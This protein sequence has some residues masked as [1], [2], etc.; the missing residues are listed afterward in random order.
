LKREQ[1]RVR[2]IPH[3]RDAEAEEKKSGGNFLQEVFGKGS[4]EEPF[5]KKVLTR[6]P[7]LCALSVSAVRDLSISVA[8]NRRVVY[9]NSIHL[10]QL[11]D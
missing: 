7:L 11:S 6:L 2:K 5:F 1:G 10:K 8:W 9:K 4:G 3:R